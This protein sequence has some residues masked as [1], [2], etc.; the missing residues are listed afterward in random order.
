M[1]APRRRS[2]VELSLQREFS[3]FRLEEQV[4]RRA[5]ELVIPVLVQQVKECEPLNSD[6]GRVL[7]NATQSQGA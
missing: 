2:K 6:A 5:F 7:V 1:E 3:G 4:L